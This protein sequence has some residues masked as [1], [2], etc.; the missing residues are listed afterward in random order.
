MG[1]S[2]SLNS[3]AQVL[4]FRKVQTCA[5]ALRPENLFRYAAARVPVALGL[6]AQAKRRLPTLQAWSRCRCWAT[7]ERPPWIPCA[8]VNRFTLLHLQ[9]KCSL[10]FF[11]ANVLLP[12][13][14]LSGVISW[15]GSI[16]LGQ[17]GSATDHPPQS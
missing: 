8:E 1:I 6:Q 15:K 3:A 5:H 2:L 16:G 7:E 17:V 9:L 10:Y 13:L 14:I 4:K 12:V 11:A